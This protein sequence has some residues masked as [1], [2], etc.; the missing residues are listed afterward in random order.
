MSLIPKETWKKCGIRIAISN[1]LMKNKKELWLKMHDIEVKLDVRNMSDL[2]KKE[3][4]G[5]FNTKNPTKE[6]IWNIIK[7]DLIMAFTLLKTLL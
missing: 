3:I 1:N 2:V 6:Q 4:H 7:H 5:I